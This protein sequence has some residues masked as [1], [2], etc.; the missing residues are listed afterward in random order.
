MPTLSYEHVW[1]S[2]IQG[3][4]VLTKDDEGGEKG[5]GRGVRVGGLWGRGWGG[6]IRDSQARP[7]TGSRD[8]QRSDLYSSAIF[9]LER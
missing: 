5:E 2:Y 3:F 7:A 8:G 4:E 6:D 9:V 1:L